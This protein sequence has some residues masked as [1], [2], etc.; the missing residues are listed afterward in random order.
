MAM[1]TQ[2]CSECQ[3]SFEPRRATQLYCSAGCSRR[4][5]ER[6]RLDKRRVTSRVAAQ[7]M[8]AVERAD[9]KAQLLAAETH[10]QRSLQAETASAADRLQRTVLKCERTIDAQ[11]TQLQRLAAAN[12]DLC[13]ELA[14]AKAETVELRLEV[15]RVLHTARAD[16]QDLMRLAGRLLELTNHVGIPLDRTTADIY[17]RR[18]WNT[19]IPVGSR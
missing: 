16:A 8:V 7:T 14:E 10:Y 18:G 6:R 3:A 11:R 1:S 4:R 19:N 15:A 9:G 2:K 13:G 17:H 5:R 12:I